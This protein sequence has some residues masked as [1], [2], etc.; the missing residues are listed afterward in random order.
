MVKE[1]LNKIRPY[2]KHI[3]NNFKKFHTWK[4]QLAIANNFIFSI[5]NDEEC[6]VHSKSENMEI[7]INDEAE[8]VIK[9]IF[10][11][12]KNSYQNNL[13]LMKGSDFVFD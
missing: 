7:M 3:K 4:I 10:D 5:D 6:A 8:E 11:S 9:L 12:L 2:L 1:Y 13:E